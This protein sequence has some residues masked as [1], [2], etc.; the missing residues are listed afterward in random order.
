MRNITALSI[1]AFALNCWAIG[2]SAQPAATTMAVP[3]VEGAL[4]TWSFNGDY[5]P[6]N[7]AGLTKPEMV[8]NDIKTKPGSSLIVGST[9]HVLPESVRM[10]AKYPTFEV[11]FK[12]ADLQQTKI[13]GQVSSSIFGAANTLNVK[14]ELNRR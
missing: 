3:K 8:S 7:G 13:P 9:A 4:N 1:F 5:A 2:A 10:S 12:A 11:A 14:T 6:T